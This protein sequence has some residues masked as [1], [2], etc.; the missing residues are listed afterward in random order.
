MNSVKITRLDELPFRVFGFHPVPHQPNLFLICGGRRSTTGQRSQ[1]CAFLGLYDIAARRFLWESNQPKN[2]PF[3]QAIVQ[4]DT[5]VAMLPN[6]F[7][8][9]PAGL[10]VFDLATGK[11][12]AT[13]EIRGAKSIDRVGEQL[14]CVSFPNALTMVDADGQV[15][16]QID[17]LSCLPGADPEHTRVQALL[18]RGDRHFVALFSQV[19]QR[20]MVFTLV[21]LELGRRQPLWQTECCGQEVRPMGRN[22]VCWDNRNPKKLRLEVICPA[23]KIET[24]VTIKTC[25]VKAVEPVDQQHIAALSLAGCYCID[26]QTNNVTPLTGIDPQQ[27]QTWTVAIPLAKPRHMLVGTV[28]DANDPTTTMQV[29]EFA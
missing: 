23:G 5:C 24:A 13:R 4:G 9:A 12:T 8:G 11:P 25:D 19:P 2:C 1:S 29:W 21:G 14:L 7:T 16:E 10:F 27:L 3:E 22:L 28:R 15:V 20:D 6:N 17:L 18:R 26:T